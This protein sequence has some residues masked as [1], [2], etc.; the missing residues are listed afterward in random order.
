MNSYIQIGAS[1]IIILI[2]IIYGRVMSY[3]QF[4]QISS[5][6]S[7]P[8]LTENPESG[9]SIF[10]NFYKRNGND[11][12]LFDL[13]KK[14]KLNNLQPVWN[15]NFNNDTERNL[16]TVKKLTPIIIVPGLGA[17]PIFAKWNK[18]SSMSVKSLDESGEFEKGDLWSCKQIQDTWK[19]IWEPHTTG[20]SSNC[21]GETTAVFP[22]GKKI[23][24]SEGTSTILNEFGSLDFISNDYM[25]YLIET[26]E[27]S[28]FTRGN[29]L[30]GAG[31]DFRKI[32]SDSEITQWCKELKNLI[33]LSCSDQEHPAVIIG[34]DLGSVI[35]N[36][37]LVNENKE[38][39]NK[40]IKSFISIS[41][42]F[43][44]T[45][46]ALRSILSGTGDSEIF[47]ETIKNF[48]GLSLMLPN[49]KV[50]GNNPLVH[51]NGISYS[52]KDIP[53]LLK[54][55]SEN[56][57]DIYEIG[58]NIRD[59]SMLSPGVPVYILCG[60][61]LDTESSYNYKN[62]LTNNPQTNYPYYQ[63]N[64][65]MNQRFHYPDYFV[66]DGTIPRFALEYPIFWTKTQKEPIDF[67]FFPGVEHTDIL[68]TYE[69]I[70]YILSVI[71]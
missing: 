53:K 44:G 6:N 21:W 66:G 28:G 16:Y 14:L 24:N 48:S 58:K 51:L 34:H 13:I 49:T 38:W 2:L 43:G 47:N 40:Y 46:K 41:G 33:E 55:V 9:L 32:G 4:S 3:E 54:N 1:I 61:E 60:D 11:F 10:L 8:I 12:R 39:K 64:L 63:T 15:G 70:K 25:S 68:S 62:S 27:S 20:L 30:F 56:A 37:F 17:T 35:A 19:K 71:Y 42:A 59:K 7:M 65:E 69:P 52:S 23:N 67:Q 57:H 36:Y 18:P 50:Y 22:D 45:P 26:L 29:N 31:Y 5:E